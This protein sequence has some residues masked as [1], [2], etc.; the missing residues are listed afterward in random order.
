VVELRR[1]LG[2]ALIVA[3]FAVVSGVPAHA[4]SSNEAP[5]ATEVGV[6]PTEIHIAAMADVDNPFAPGLFQGAVDGVNGAAAYVNSKAGGGGIA[7]RKL[8]VDFVDSKLNPNESRNGV[9]KA[10]ANDLALVGTASLFLSNVDDE[11]N[12]KD[13]AGAATGLPDMGAIV[14]GVPETC[15]PVSFPVLGSQ[16][17]CTTKDEH[18]QTYLAN[19]GDS[20]F[21]LRTHK[22]GLHGA[23]VVSNDTK[24]ANRGGAIQADAAIHAGV[25]PD[26]NVTRSGKD[27]QSAYT[28]IV[29]KM[30]SD[31]SNYALNVLAVNSEI[32]LR[33]EA[34][35]QGLTDPNIVWACTEACYDKSAKQ[36]ADVMNGTSVTLSY[37]PFEE[38]NSNAMEKNFVKYVGKDKIDGFAVSGWVAGLEFAQAVKA[39]VAKHGVNGLTRA[40]LIEGIKTI[41]DFNAGGMIGTVP[42][43]TRGLSPCFVIVQLK[44]GNFT[45]VYPK[46]KGTF[47]C[48]PSNLVKIQA[49]LIGT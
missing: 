18:P 34:Q 8:V 23:M 17:D 35:L 2:V 16:L 9:I 38:A 7:G 4:Q 46:K 43:A 25:K 31:A 47:D 21:Y 39:A 27:P 5:K 19:I 3:A 41:K 32:E 29:N 20:K 42:V 15:S 1:A 12:C 6:T 28:A 49:D 22:N 33:S 44:N 48:K 30:K 10:C 14:A 36:N 40:S 45:R 13:Q 26:Q 11:I 24:D 37:L